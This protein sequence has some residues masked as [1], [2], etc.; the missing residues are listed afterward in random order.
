MLTERDLDLP[1]MLG[2][3]VMCSPPPR[4]TAAQNALWRGIEDGTIDIFNSDHAP[5]RFDGE[6]KLKAG[7]NAPFRAVANGIPGLETRMAILF[8]EGVVKGRI[9]LPRFVALTS[10]NNAKL[11]G[12]HPQKGTITVGADADIVLW[13]PEARVTIT[14]DL[15]HHNVDYTPFEGLEVEGWPKTAISRG[16]IIVDDGQLIGVPGRGRFLTQEISSAWRTRE[17]KPWI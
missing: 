13:D 17:M 12:L 1:G 14:N 7:L 3:K 2:A 16:E 6:G 8:S 15:L 9:D 11:Y 4:D 10:T 5:Y